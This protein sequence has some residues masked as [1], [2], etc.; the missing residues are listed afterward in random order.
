MA[1][2]T[3]RITET[4]LYEAVFDLWGFSI[5]WIEAIDNALM[6]FCDLGTD[7]CE[8]SMCPANMSVCFRSIDQSRVEEAKRIFIRLNNLAAAAMKGRKPE[9]VD[10][11]L[12]CG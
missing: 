2:H 3:E 9:D 10:Y 8:S 5:G 7:S 6:D 1:K 4:V 11:H 12:S